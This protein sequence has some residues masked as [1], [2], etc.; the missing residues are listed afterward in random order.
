VKYIKKIGSKVVHVIRSDIGV[1]PDS[2]LK[3]WSWCGT[4]F[5]SWALSGDDFVLV[6]GHRLGNFKKCKKC[7]K[8]G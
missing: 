2:A 4:P 3:H 8:K 7:F 5:E 1:I 6:D